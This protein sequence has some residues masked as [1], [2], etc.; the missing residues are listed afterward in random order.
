MAI[1]M[2][3]GS[4]MGSKGPGSLEISKGEPRLGKKTLASNR[5]ARSVVGRSRKPE[6]ML[7]TP[8]PL[9]CGELHFWLELEL[10]AVLRVD[11]DSRVREIQPL[12]H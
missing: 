10:Q 8:L 12:E 1:E 2:T 5:F 3:H 11:A 9:P 4:K 7:Q 6:H